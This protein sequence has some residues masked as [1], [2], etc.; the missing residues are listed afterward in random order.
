MR[1]RRT[2]VAQAKVA[3]PRSEAFTLTALVVL[4]LIALAF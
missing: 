3:R 2:R 4:S 1:N